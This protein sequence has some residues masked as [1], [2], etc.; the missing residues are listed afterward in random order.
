MIADMTRGRINPARAALGATLLSMAL[1]ASGCMKPV[2]ENDDAWMV[3]TPEQERRAPTQPAV[4]PQEAVAEVKQKA[5]ITT[6]KKPTQEAPAPEPAPAAPVHTASELMGKRQSEVTALMGAPARIEQRAASTVWVYQGGDCGLDVFFFLDM[7]TSDER[8]LTVAPSAESAAA[9]ARKPTSPAAAG[10]T[11]S[12]E[13]A[14]GPQNPD[15]TA[16]DACYGKLRRS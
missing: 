4:R 9:A 7:A 5:P 6:S 12:A 8:V 2:E 10:E 15:D 13:V 1:L 3:A 14:S 16:I 11:A